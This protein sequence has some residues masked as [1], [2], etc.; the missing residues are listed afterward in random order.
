MPQAS[1]VLPLGEG[2]NLLFYISLQVVIAGHPGFH[3]Y[4]NQNAPHN[5]FLDHS[6][7]L[8]N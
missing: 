2:K 3:G 5:F 7:E 6:T 1:K 4:R 8:K